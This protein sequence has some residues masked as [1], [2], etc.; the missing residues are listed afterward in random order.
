M[1]GKFQRSSTRPRRI[2]YEDAVRTYKHASTGGDESKAR[3]ELRCVY[4]G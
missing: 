3:A 4:A 1:N 2:S